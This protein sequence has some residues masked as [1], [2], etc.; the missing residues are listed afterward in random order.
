MAD[1]QEAARRTALI[2]G[3]S[4]GIGLAFAKA[5]AEQGFDLV[6]T[7]RREEQLREIATKLEKEFGI[8]TWVIQGDL[9]DPQ[10]PQ[11]IFDATQKLGVAI[12]ALVNNAGYG[13]RGTFANTQWQDQAKFIQVMATAVGHLCHLFLPGMVAR[14]YGRIINVASV[15]GILPGSPGMTLY[16]ATK[17]FVIQLS[18]TL[19]LEYQQKGVHVCASCPGFTYTDFQR[20]AEIDHITD[21]QVPKMLW[22]ET[23]VVARGSIEAVMRGNPRYIPGIVNKLGVILAEKILPRRVALWVAKSQMKD[24]LNDTKREITP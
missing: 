14:G 11:R 2:T 17:S 1:Q 20:N 21:R 16:G 13:L 22:M 6:L 3:A 15:S 19:H 7:A 9:A 10:V 5:F 24:L 18:E 12:D 23:D 4:A 8:R